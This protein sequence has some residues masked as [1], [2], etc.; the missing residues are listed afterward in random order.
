MKKITAA[1]IGAGQRGKK[2]CVID[3]QEFIKRF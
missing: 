2:D 1:L 3:M